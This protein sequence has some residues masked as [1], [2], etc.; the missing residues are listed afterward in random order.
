L[1]LR[2]AGLRYGERGFGLNR[3]RVGVL[4]VT[5]AVSVTIDT[6]DWNVGEHCQGFVLVFEVDVDSF[7]V[8]FDVA[9]DDVDK[10][11]LH[12]IDHIGR[13]LEMVGHE[14]ETQAFLGRC[15]RGLPSEQAI[16]KLD[17]R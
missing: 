8:D 15:S 7:A 14:D 16:E 17:H 9:G 2:L 6:G 13:Q 5:A 10:I 1:W 3:F 4:G 12:R 11:A